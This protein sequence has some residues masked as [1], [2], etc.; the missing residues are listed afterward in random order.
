MAFW[1]G[2]AAN[3]PQVEIGSST[4]AR[5]AA[6]KLWSARLL[7]VALAIGQMIDVLTT[8]R[9]LSAGGREMNPVMH[10]AMEL[11]GGQ[12]WLWKAFIAVF[13]ICLAITVRQPS[14]RKVVL[15]GLVA[16]AQAIVIIN[17]VMHS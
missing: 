2:R 11:S 12:W 4:T 16:V 1:S 5:S 3:A 8:N 6:A 15:A 7:L 17:N 13:L 9:A 14:W 10:L